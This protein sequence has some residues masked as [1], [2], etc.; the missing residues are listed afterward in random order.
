MSD[1][2]VVEA[3]LRSDEG[4]GASRRLRRL[5]AKIPAIIYGGDQ[6]PV[7]LSLIRKDLE[8]QLESEAFYSA[9]ITV[10]YDGKEDQAI[11]KDLQRHPAK[12]YPMHADF[13]RVQANKAIKVSIPIHFTNEE[14]CVGVKL[15][16]GRIQHLLNEV[17]V[18]SLPKDLP[19][20]IEVD[21]G[22]VEVGQIVHLSDLSFPEGV[23]ST[24]LALG[25]DRDDGVAQVLAPRGGAQESDADSTD[26]SESDAGDS[27][28]ESS[29]DE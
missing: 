29:D 10:N 17:E 11:L 26:E 28:A 4:K 18:L 20:F 23:S 12:D 7:S 24:A 25:S 21:M 13:L 6:P 2:F 1:A 15:G 22:Q 27:D 16:G 9:I 5:E 14:T 19:D 3:E 8:K